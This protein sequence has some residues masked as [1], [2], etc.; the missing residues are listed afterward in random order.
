MPRERSALYARRMADWN[1]SNDAIAALLRAVDVCP[2]RGDGAEVFIINTLPRGAPPE[3]PGPFED[4]RGAVMR[5]APAVVVQLTYG[6]SVGAWRFTADGA[7]LD[8]ITPS[9]SAPGAQGAAR[10]WR[11]WFKTFPAVD[12][13]ELAAVGFPSSAWSSVG[14]IGGLRLVLSLTVAAE[15]MRTADGVT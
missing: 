6:A 10:D 8:A 14:T 12:R 3:S 7:P 11:A 5:G 4:T 1:L 15:R 13:A 2:G 9:P